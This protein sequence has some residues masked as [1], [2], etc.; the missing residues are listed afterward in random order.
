MATPVNNNLSVQPP[1]VQPT[2]PAPYQKSNR[3][4]YLEQ[5]ASKISYAQPDIQQGLEQARQIQLQQAIAQSTG[6]NIPAMAGQIGT[7]MAN[8]QAEQTAQQAKTAADQLT[9]VAAL[10]SE[11]RKTESKARAAVRDVKLNQKQIELGN[12]LTK[13]DRSVRDKLLDKQL[14]F[15]LDS[16]G[17][18]LLSSRQLL[19]WT[20]L[21]A[22]KDEQ[23]KNR[24]QI[25]EQAYDKKIQILDT[26]KNKIRQQ[27]EQAYLEEKQ[28]LDNRTIYQ[29][30]EQEEALKLA[31]QRE[32]AKK[33]SRAA[34]YGGIG[35]MVGLGV[36]VAAAPMTGGASLAY[37]PAAMAA[38]GGAGTV[39]A[40]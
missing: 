7:G 5:L 14:K 16:A 23:F 24:A 40:N 21:N 37:A 3:A 20:A 12:Q 15:K 18:A 25:M 30:K 35:S 17:Q 10:G 32:Q 26:A 33:A 1:A 19:D 9:T 29:L 8:L 4:K 36:A 28:T 22:E 2:A 31:I 38:G 34:M 6:S 13:L 11:Q 39:L 27:I